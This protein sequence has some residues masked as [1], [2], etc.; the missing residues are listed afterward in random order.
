MPIT[1]STGY[2]YGML[3]NPAGIAID[4]TGGVWI[5]NKNGNSVTHVFGAA[6]PVATPLSNA[7]SNSTLGAKP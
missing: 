2:A 4:D 6:A 7:T 3:S 5:V 1:G